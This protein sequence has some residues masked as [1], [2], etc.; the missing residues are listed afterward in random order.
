M[1]VN[2]DTFA[3]TPLSSKTLAFSKCIKEEHMQRIR[4][5]IARGLQAMNMDFM[6]MGR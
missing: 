6:A 5:D 3:P 4:D 2:Q 1:A